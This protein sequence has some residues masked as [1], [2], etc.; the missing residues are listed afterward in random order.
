MSFVPTEAEQQLVNALFSAG[1]PQKLGII[2]GDNAVKILAG[3]KLPANVLGEVWAIADSENN[4]FLTRKGAATLVRL[5]GWA[6]KGESVN[7]DLLNRVG[8]LPTIDGVQFPKS[9]LP[10]TSPK[11]SGSPR[12][13]PPL[14]AE[15]RAKF[16][17]LFVGCAPTNGLLTGEKARDVFLKSNLPLEKLGQIWYGPSLANLADTQARGALDQADFVIGMYFIQLAMSQPTLS[18]PANLPPGLYEQAN[19]GR[20]AA[21]VKSHAT[22]SSIGAATPIVRPGIGSPV[23]AQYTGQ[24]LRQQVTGQPLSSQNTGQALGSPQHTGIAASRLSI[25]PSALTTFPGSS[26]QPP[27][28]GAWDISAQEKATADSF[29]NGLD[30]QRRGYIE[31][32][33][34]VPFMLKSGLEEATLARIWDLADLHKDGKL[35]QEGFAIALHLINGKL[36]GK[37]VPDSLP[38]GLVP[39]S[40]RQEKPALSQVQQDLWLLGD[41]PPASA[42]NPPPPFAPQATGGAQP[43]PLQQAFNFKP[44]GDLLGDDDEETTPPPKPSG[45]DRSIEIGNTQNQLRNTNQSL[46]A[47]KKERVS[48][49]NDVASSAATL[50][51]LET[52]LA[53]SKAAFET[54]T[55]LISDLREK[56]LAQTTSI[57]K[58]RQ[59]LITA[60]S[61]LSALRQQKDEISG[62]LLRD[63]DEVRDLQ[64]QM[65]QVADEAELIK[66]DI[67]KLKKDARHQ[68]GLL[69][70]GRKQLATAE[71]EREKVEKERDEASQELAEVTAEVEQLSVAEVPST[72]A[73]PAATTAGVEEPLSFAAVFSPNDVDAVSSPVSTKSNNPF[74]KLALA[75]GSGSNT[76]KSTQPF[77]PFVTPTASIMED[78]RQASVSDNDPFG[79]SSVF[80]SQ[81]VETP[82]PVASQVVTPMPTGP[83]AR[84]TSPEPITTPARVASP[85]G[86][87]TTPEARKS[88]S[89]IPASASLD[90]TKREDTLTTEA[91]RFPALEDNQPVETD[92]PP[93]Q[94]IAEADDSSSDDDSE[95]YIAARAQPTNGT[96]P[97]T[98]TPQADV[99]NTSPTPRASSPPAKE[100][101]G[102]TFD[103]LFGTGNT[104]SIISGAASSRPASPHNRD[105]GSPTPSGTLSA[106]TG[107]EAT[108]F[109]PPTSQNLA[110]PKPS[111][112]TV[113]EPPKTATVS[114]FD[115]SFGLLGTK[116][117]SSA[118]TSAAFS[119]EDAF[120]ET[121]DFS[122]S[123]GESS[124]EP[125]K[126]STG[127][128][129]SP[130][131]TDLFSNTFFGEPAAPAPPPATTSFENA[132][133]LGT[134]V[135][136]PSKPK[137]PA[138]LTFNGAFGDLATP[139]A[140]EPTSP[141]PSVTPSRPS[142]DE[143][144]LIP[145][146]S[147]PRAKVPPAEPQIPPSSS[148]Q[149][150]PGRAT[151]PVPGGSASTMPGAFQQ[152]E[153]AS[154]PKLSLKSKKGASKAYQPPPGPP[155]A[156][157]QP[158]PVKH[159]KFHFPGFGRSKTTKKPAKPE[160]TSPPAGAAPSSDIASSYSASSVNATDASAPGEDVEGVRRL[161]TMGFSREQSVAALEK[162]S[163]D[164]NRALNELIESSAS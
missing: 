158:A 7:E 135:E 75:S 20:A 15:D 98:K 45:P 154:S 68:K 60:E 142:A 6:Q 104:G 152:T 22:G 57:N 127:D 134:P 29:F 69:A 9:P 97:S 65:R 113:L 120:G 72:S 146:S 163:Y 85:P 51:Q 94:E 92:L 128:A 44:A 121:F 143:N 80:A 54:E 49:E 53:A 108:P 50:A 62:S 111:I 156:V 83:L 118:P 149:F 36:T 71:S 31:G 76:P 124:N 160:K 14:S 137:S 99:S 90:T 117:N 106:A 33:V 145:A 153:R 74:E 102:S 155:P 39:P 157:E 129:T 79:L 47:A 139:K 61:D 123:G 147:P 136:A 116:P 131:G 114:D 26:Q 103:E 13:L 132:F 112:E 46:E 21:S 161:I 27:T 88:T 3:A 109:E 141:Q 58:T 119:F 56:Y 35:T 78:Q 66:K 93:L 140:Q 5:I 84:S 91:N 67:E 96:S 70:I 48:L 159:S 138:G 55:R 28:T 11:I 100:A 2:S 95:D 37:E 1:D 77:L 164:F 18:L 25:A 122:K 144:S 52:Q 10:P 19:G 42:N 32:D 24:G 89:P 107:K 105:G 81:A 17:R 148:S 12:P 87:E 43:P 125:P 82:P 8:P 4:G 38:P 101:T 162:H 59:E 110:V 115:E 133:N 41:T 63:K 73:S 130:K 64:R 16:T 34:A 150:R 30:T 23:K 126:P 40:M 151:S 86:V